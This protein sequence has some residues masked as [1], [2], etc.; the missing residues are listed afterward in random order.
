MNEHNLSQKRIQKMYNT[1]MAKVRS[2]KLIRNPFHYEEYSDPH[3]S[4]SVT[5]CVFHGAG[6]ISHLERESEGKL[7]EK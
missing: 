6:G 7:R 5:L 1:F 3:S 4:S 2:L